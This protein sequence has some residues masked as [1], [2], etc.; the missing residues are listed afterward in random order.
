[1]KK[2][3]KNLLMLLVMIFSLC[4]FA[5]FTAMASD[6]YP[7]DARIEGIEI[8]PANVDTKTYYDDCYATHGGTANQWLNLNVSSR[9]AQDYKQ[10]NCN[11]FY[12]K[13]N[14]GDTFEANTYKAYSNGSLV[15]QGPCYSS[16]NEYDM[17]V[18]CDNSYFDNNYKIHKYGSWKLVFYGYKQQGYPLYG[19]IY[20]PA[21]E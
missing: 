14:V 3:S 16:S 10:K 12:I 21:E 13:V 11:G 18:R 6:G 17:Y 5:S 2:K 20:L 4:T 9:F 15:K 7:S 8:Y 19:N 1:M